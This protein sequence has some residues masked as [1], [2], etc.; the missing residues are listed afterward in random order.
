MRPED[1]FE[2]IHKGC[3]GVVSV[4]P[5]NY[6]TK[7]LV[8]CTLC[9][10]YYNTNVPPKSRDPRLQVGGITGVHKMSKV[11]LLFWLFQHKGARKNNL[12]KVI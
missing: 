3:G 6:P 8:G 10:D 4:Y 12:G 1:I 5:Q 2:G 7:F 9:G 11:H